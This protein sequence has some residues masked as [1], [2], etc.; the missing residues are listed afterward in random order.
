ME[1]PEI[2]PIQPGE[3]LE[4]KRVIYTVAHSIFHDRPTLEES[5][6]FYETSWPIPDVE[7][8]QRSYVENGGIFL[9]TAEDGAIIGTGAL[10]R[11]EEGVG[12]IK[13][14][15]LLPEHHGRGLGYRMMAALMAAA[16]ERGY[17]RLR[18][19]TSPRWQRRAFEFYKRL[20]FYEIPLYENDEDDMVGMECVLQPG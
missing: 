20:G 18:L 16:R 13:R 4:A 2:R 10:R 19:T 5:I 1:M 8:Y 17:T 12:E 6:A 7:D 3:V 11:L 15:W 9:V 14:L